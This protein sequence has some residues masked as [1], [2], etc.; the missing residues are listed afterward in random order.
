MDRITKRFGN[1]A[2]L[3]GVSLDLFAGEVHALLGCNGAG[4]S[5]L[6]KI[7]AGVHTCD[8]GTIS[9][10]GKPITPRSPAQAARLGIAVIHQELSLV[11][12][13]S[14]TE[15]LLLGRPMT[16]FG[17][18]SRKNE[19]AYAVKRLAEVG[20]SVDPDKRVE[21]LTLA[22][23]QLVEIAK[24]LGLGARV[25][26][27]DEPTSA[28][29]APSVE[30][31]FDLVRSLCARGV[32]VVYVSHRM[33]EITQLAQRLTV[34][35]DGRV[36]GRARVEETRIEEIVGWMLGARNDVAV[37]TAKVAVLESTVRL[38][39]R[40]F[41]V[42]AEQSTRV[43]VDRVSLSVNAGEIVG[44]FGL[45]GAGA[46]DLVA[47]LFGTFGK[48]STGKVCLDGRDVRI[49]SPRDGVALGLGF[50]PADRKTMGIVPLLSS[51]HNATLPVLPSL[52]LWGWIQKKRD[53]ATAL[54]AAKRTGLAT[55]ALGRAIVELSG[56]NQ[57]KVVLGKWLVADPRVLLLDDPTRGVDVGAKA[58]MYAFLRA[59]A[60]RGAGVLVASSDAQ[61]LMD[62]CDRILVLRKGKI[63][64]TVR[65]SECGAERLLVLA[66]EAGIEAR[67]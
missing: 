16:R 9:L 58:E 38:D 57:Q 64:A 31:L 54:D 19:R 18:V 46:S 50:V 25:L 29:T 20:L 21:T 39:V 43:V 1:V 65:S 12:G 53:D 44:C 67:A 34:L 15:N 42:V 30:K 11:P 62:V 63:V 55:E 26:V 60:G 35:R 49:E 56:G 10:E 7:L 33:E 22:E 36:V 24:A 51:A 6:L 8:S 47:G 4:K 14:V 27:M 5:T 41:C 2:V 59:L 13:L 37:E 52:S 32:A 28:L 3:D 40:D 17:F 61:E 23:R 66:M 48:R 45:S